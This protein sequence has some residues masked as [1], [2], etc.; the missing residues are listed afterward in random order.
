MTVIF[1]R[2]EWTDAEISALVQ[3]ICLFWDDAGFD[4]Q[5]MQSDPKFWDGCADAVSK[6]FKFFKDRFV[7]LYSSAL[8]FE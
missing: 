5:P 7:K 6:T 1:G 2:K 8:F 4:K 3:Y